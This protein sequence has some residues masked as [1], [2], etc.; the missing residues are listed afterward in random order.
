MYVDVRACSPM[1][2]EEQTQHNQ[3]LKRAPPAIRNN[4]QLNRQVAGKSY[5]TNLPP[6]DGNWSN[7]PAS[8]SIPNMD[9][10]HLFAKAKMTCRCR[11]LKK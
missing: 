9:F 6:D 7:A 5:S 11:I 4:P 2:A 3:F 1:T 8:K 10:Y